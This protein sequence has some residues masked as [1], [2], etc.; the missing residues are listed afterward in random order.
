MDNLVNIENMK[1]A[2]DNNVVFENFK[3]SLKKGKWYTLC[4]PNGSGKTTLIKILL[5]ILK[6]KGI[7]KFDSKLLVE[8]STFEIRKDIGVVFSNVN[9]Q[10]VQETVY[11]EVAFKMV[12][13]G[14][15]K[16][17]IDER[18]SQILKYFDMSKIVDENPHKINNSKK[19]LV[20][21][22]SAIVSEPKLIVIDE[23]LTKCDDQDK[24][25]VIS[26]LNE[27]VK[28]GATV[29]NVTNNMEDSIY[30]D[31]IIILEKGSIY[32]M[33]PLKEVFEDEIKLN[34]LGIELPFIVLLSHRMKFYELIDDV[35]LDMKSMVDELWQ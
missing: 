26:L 31:E 33:G 30:S 22:A 28:E 2:Y 6:P 4:G 34:R 10:F 17:V 3:L 24:E 13:M 5:G 12:N 23:A 29:I 16:K 9:N 14:F 21:F 32:L 20:A 7:I 35:I 11:D 15:D 25:K 19:Q 18:V 8:S 1:F 27:L